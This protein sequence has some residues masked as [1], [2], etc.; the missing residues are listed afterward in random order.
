MSHM[1]HNPAE[2]PN[3]NLAIFLTTAARLKYGPRAYRRQL[4]NIRRKLAELSDSVIPEHPQIFYKAYVLAADWIASTMLPSVAQ[5]DE[6]DAMTL[7]AI[8]FARQVRNV[9]FAFTA[10]NKYRHLSSPSEI[11]ENL[12]AEVE[13]E[14]ETSY[15]AVTDHIVNHLA[16]N[17]DL[18]YRDAYLEAV[19]ILAQWILDTADASALD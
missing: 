16:S 15:A 9:I 13:A 7:T 5:G 4:I 14:A 6:D 18:S 17:L 11:T 3:E 10:C 19:R 12:K 1:S 8:P 2:Y